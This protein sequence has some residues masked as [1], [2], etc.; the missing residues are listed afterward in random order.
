MAYDGIYKA[1]ISDP[2]LANASQSS[3]ILELIHTANLHRGSRNTV[4]QAAH[5]LARG[6][7]MSEALQ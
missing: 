5:K 7:I 1:D 3:I 6:I 2:Q 4:N